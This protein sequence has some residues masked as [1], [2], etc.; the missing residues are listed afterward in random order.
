MRILL[1]ALIAVSFL[2]CSSVSNHSDTHRGVASY[3]VPTAEQLFLRGKYL[4][5]TTNPFG[6][7][8]YGEE[9]DL[10]ARR[11]V[12][13]LTGTL[14]HSKYGTE[15]STL[16]ANLFHDGKFWIARIPRVGVKNVY[17]I[18]SYFPPKT[19]ALPFFPSQYIA[20]HSLLR[21][22]MDPA[23]PIE[24]VAEMPDEATLDKLRGLDS[25][26][27]FKL[28]PEAFTGADH[29]LINVGIS[30]EAQWT[31]DDP[32][33][34]YDLKRGLNDAFIQVVRMVSMKERFRGFYDNGR[35]TNEIKLE[36]TKPLDSILVAGMAISQSDALTKAYNTL[37]Y[38]CTTLAFDIVEQGLGEKD[39]RVGEVRKFMEKRIPIIAPSK[40]KGYNGGQMTVL[41]MQMDKTMAS[42][43]LSA[44]IDV[45]ETP[46]RAL[47]PPSFVDETTGNM[48]SAM[49]VLREAYP[50]RKFPANCR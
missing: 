14:F 40:V 9:L 47:C 29:Q 20:A 41:P 5:Q 49:K 18:L 15:D 1:S 17:F 21:F 19:P 42:E 32:K 16:V 2:G 28:L 37:Q 13:N 11:P 27:A 36:T 33:K 39:P 8:H 25:S 35:P 23:H 26:E 43:S 31:K 3:E 34:A 12:V 6:E 48:N 50:T 24:L 44:Y 30:A 7:R 10:S 22:E 4:Y 46:K 45:V 38:N